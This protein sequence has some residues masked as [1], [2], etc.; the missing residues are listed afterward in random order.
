M[1]ESYVHANSKPCC[2][3]SFI[4][5]IIRWY[6]GS[7]RTV[8]PKLS[9]EPPR[10]LAGERA[11]R[12]EIASHSAVELPPARVRRGRRAPIPGGSQRRARRLGA[13]PHPGGVRLLSRRR[14]GSTRAR[15]VRLQAAALLDT[16]RR[17]ALVGLDRRRAR[18][19]LR[20]QLDLLRAEVGRR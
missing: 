3:A 16:A 4:S 2:S 18:R 12:R 7:G 14:A 17:R 15:R 13:Q 20:G 6:G 11:Y 19:L 10:S 8:T 5:S 9:M 1:C